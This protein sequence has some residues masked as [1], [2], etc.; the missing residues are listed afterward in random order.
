MFRCLIMGP[1][2]S[3]KTFISKKVAANYG[4]IYFSAEDMV[5]QHIKKKSPQ[6][7]EAFKYVNV[8]R[9]VPDKLLYSIID[10]E[11]ELADNKSFI[12]DDF[13][14]TVS[15]AKHLEDMVDL[16]FVLNLNMPDSA[17]V[18]LLRTREFH[19]PSD[20]EYNEQTNAP[21]TRGLDD[22]TSDKLVR[23]PKDD[24]LLM[25]KKLKK[26]VNQNWPIYRYYQRKFKVYNVTGRTHFILWP[27]VRK[28][29]NRRLHLCPDLKFTPRKHTG[30]MHC[31]ENTQCC[32][33]WRK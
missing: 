30:L 23:L 18:N 33:N 17:I 13:P 1:P 27:K 16:D 11:I 15:Q 19:T 22:Q 21:Y 8:N 4:A 3:G 28:Y 9:P 25:A 14:R 6:G 12:L 29:M 24:P 7:R 10:R 32:K 26:F 2:G 31:F 20:R 5:R